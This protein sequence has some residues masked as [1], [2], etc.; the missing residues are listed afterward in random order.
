MSGGHSAA[1]FKAGIS[2]EL[3]LSRS[4]SQLRLVRTY[5]SVPSPHMCNNSEMPVPH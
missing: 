5:V 1:M 4:S 2:G 3:P